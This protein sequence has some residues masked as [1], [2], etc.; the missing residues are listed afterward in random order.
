MKQFVSK[1]SIELL[2]D[3]VYVEL[4]DAPASD[5]IITPDIAKG[6]PVRGKIIATGPGR[7]SPKDGRFLPMDVAPGDLVQFHFGALEHFW[8]DHQK[9]R[10]ILKAQHIQAVIG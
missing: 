6:L 8:P 7:K 2:R 3:D 4:I 9:E 5:I 10:G 1:E